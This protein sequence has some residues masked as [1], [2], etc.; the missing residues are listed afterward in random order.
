[1]TQAVAPAE[2]DSIDRD[3]YV[4]GIVESNDVP[5]V[6]D[7]PA[8]RDNGVEFISHGD[9]AALVGPIGSG[10]RLGRRADLVAHSDV[11]NGVAATGTPVI[12]VEFGSVLAES[13]EVERELLA[14]N[15]EHWLEMLRYLRGTNQFTIRGTYDQAEILGEAV[16]ENADI[17]ELRDQTIGRDDD[18]SY[19]ARVRLGELVARAIDEKRSADVELLSGVLEPHCVSQRITTG[20]GLDGLVDAAFLVSDRQRAEFEAAAEGL[21]EQLHDRARLKLLGPLAPFD[22]V[23]PE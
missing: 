3:W 13:G 11:L 9:V 19:G 23:R 20:S 14:P 10:R 8:L 6:R 22:F 1:M 21:A 15:T 17:A 5:A 18:E 7:A 16:R 2:Q 12:P 4:Y